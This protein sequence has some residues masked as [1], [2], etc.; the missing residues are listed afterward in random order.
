[1]RKGT[2]AIG[3]ALAAALAMGWECGDTPATPKSQCQDGSTKT[4]TEHHKVVHYTCRNG[5]W[6]RD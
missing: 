6:I 3:L 5:E 1:M 4:T 2:V